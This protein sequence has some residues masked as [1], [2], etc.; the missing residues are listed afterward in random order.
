[1]GL[2]LNHT[3]RGGLL[4]ALA[5][6]TALAALAALSAC[7]G[8]TPPPEAPTQDS[9]SSSGRQSGSGMGVSA[10][11]GA[12]DEAETQ[13]VF[14]KAA[15]KLSRCFEQGLRRVP[16][17]GGEVRLAARVTASGSARWVYVKDSTLGDRQAEACMVEALRG[18]TWPK[19]VGGEGLAENSYTFEPS[20]D[21]RQPVG[22]SSDALGAPFQEALPQLTTCRKDAGTGALK[23]TLYV[24]PEG[25]VVSAGVSGSDD[26]AESAATCVVD[27]LRGVTFP[28]PGSYDAKVSVAID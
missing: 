7:G 14:E 13:A 18:A 16:Y 11:I 17:L 5:A 3:A 27:A 4:S 25:K 28:S 20:P 26:R 2:S 1:M 22:W 19:P 24:D 9:G 10:E 15:P 23:A 8:S 12:L 6:L 21:E